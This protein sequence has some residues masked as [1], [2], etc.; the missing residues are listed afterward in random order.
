MSGLGR[1]D[2]RGADVRGPGAW[3]TAVGRDD[4]QGSALVIRRAGPGDVGAIARLAELDKAP[5]P[6]EPLVLAEM[7]GELWVAVSLV[8]LD[9]IADPFR[10]SAAIAEL[11]VQ[12]ARQLRGR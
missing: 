10:R 11:T 3:A 9:H 2:A 4:W 5:V 8:N 6:P 1:L 12:R 7:A